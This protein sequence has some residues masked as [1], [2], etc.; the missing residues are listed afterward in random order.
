MNKYDVR[1]GEVYTF[2]HAKAGGRCAVKIKK[3]NPK[4]VKGVP[5]LGRPW[6]VHPSFLVDDATVAEVEA[7]DSAP[8]AAASTSGPLETGMV[9]RFL[10]KREGNVP[11]VIIGK[12]GATFRVTKLG[13]DGGRYWPGVMPE[14][15]EVL[16]INFALEDA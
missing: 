7:F 10:D 3:I 6:N 12:H 1:V 14:M 4:N 5:A 11:F 16:D 13:G 15:L 8:S 9:V 2:F